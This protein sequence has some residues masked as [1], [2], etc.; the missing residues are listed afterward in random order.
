M[1]LQE[2]GNR[3]LQIRDPNGNWMEVQA[4]EDAAVAGPDSAWAGCPEEASV[5][6]SHKEREATTD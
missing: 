4:S 1:E 6:P 3:I 2:Q 5:F